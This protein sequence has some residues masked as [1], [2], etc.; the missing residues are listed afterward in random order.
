MDGLSNEPKS[1]PATAD[2]GAAPD[3]AFAPL[4]EML[5]ESAG[6]PAPEVER[7]VRAAIPSAL[8]DLVE[9]RRR[10]R[11]GV[12]RRDSL[13]S[14]ASTELRATA[15]LL[16]GRPGEEGDRARRLDR[17][18]EDLDHA[19]HGA[20]L[21][22]RAKPR[23]A[24]P[25]AHVLV[26]DDEEDARAALQLVL[27][28]DY[29]VDAVGDGQEAL[30]RV[31]SERPDVVLLDLN[32]P[33]LDGLEVLERLRADPATAEI[34]VL[35][36][37]GRSDDAVKVR[38]LDLGAVD[39]LQKPFSERELRARVDRTL[40]LM[41]SQ[42]ALR[43]LAQTDMLTGLAN[44][45]A[46]RARLD[47]EVKRARRYHT[48]LT[49]VMADMDNL[50]PINDELGHAAG[51]RA[52]AAVAAVIRAELRETDF[53]ARYGGDEFVVLLPHTEA[54]EGRVFA[55]RVLDRLRAAALE[56]G[57]RRVTL[58]ASFGVAALPADAEV[59]PEA[60]V[61]AADSALY[62]AKRAGRGRVAVAE[63]ELPLTP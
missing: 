11:E 14:A 31:H 29:E 23:R 16:R 50:K 18:A 39:Y 1:A 63:A 42:S 58:A 56:L 2:G 47:E 57:G 34:P 20:A 17:M 35:L 40:R 49:C 53:G 22:P 62:A 4:V 48:P 21:E 38:S 51:D 28:R 36:V 13:L 59:L 55:E 52:I 46:F 12:L 45:R 10:L 41:R 9:S 6:L 25:R 37:S 44:L 32:M 24:T 43:E 61:H 5:V 8:A 33:R 60:L 7:R 19:V 27:G 3:D 30:D 26:A 15:A 54:D